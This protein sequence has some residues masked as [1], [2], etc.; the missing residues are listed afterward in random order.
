MFSNFDLHTFVIGLIVVVLSITLHEFGHA[1][2]ADLLGD[3]TPRRQGRI[4]L[5]PDKHFDMLGFLLI[6]FSSL[7][8]FGIGYGKPV[9][10]NPARLRHPNRDMILITACGPLMNL[11]LAIVFGL[12][13]RIADATG[14]SAW[15][16]SQSLSYMFVYQFLFRN[17]G[18]MFF[19]LIPVYPLDGSKILYGI[20]PAR[21]ANAYDSF[22]R[23]WS[24]I[25]FMVI[26]CSGS[27]LIGPILTP[28]ITTTA[29][30]ITGL[31]WQ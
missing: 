12:V 6:V 21:N 23:Q 18:L 25:L 4:T 13:M 1:I 24:P 9:Q 28:A 31:S 29:R 8:G 16:D 14:H 19:N 22:M 5:W 10:V 20:L 17:L 3:D 7:A 11:L 15:L 2:S 26:L 27:A 30:I